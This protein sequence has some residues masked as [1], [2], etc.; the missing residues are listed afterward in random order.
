MSRNA[1]SLGL[2]PSKFATKPVGCRSSTSSP[3]IS[4]PLAL[5]SHRLKLKT[6]AHV[7]RDKPPWLPGGPANPEQFV[8]DGGI[9]QETG[10][11]AYRRTYSVTFWPAAYPPSRP[12]NTSLPEH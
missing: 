8:G 3:F 2:R 1:F 7:S 12:V 4:S 5:Y 6:R 11:G 9:R 10:R